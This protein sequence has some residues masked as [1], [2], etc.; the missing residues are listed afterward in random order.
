MIRRKVG[1]FSRLKLSK[2]KT[3]ALLILL[4]AAILEVYIHTSRYRI[5]VPER[6]LDE[7]FYTSC[8]EPPDPKDKSRPRANAALVMLVRN[9]E[10]DGAL[11]TVASVER[12][13][14]RWF[15]YP[16]VFLNDEPWTE[17]FKTAMRA[18]ISGEVRFEAIPTREWTFP[19]WMDT[20]AARASIKSQGQWM[21]KFAGL[22]TYHH[23]CR[24]YSGKFYNL[25]ALRQYKWYWRIEPGVEFYCDITYDPFLEMEKNG[26]VYGHTIAVPEG[27]RTCPS[28]FRRMSDWKEAHHIRDTE[29]WKTMVSPSW[30]PWPLRGLLAWL[31]WHRDR[32]G[33]AWSLCH[34][35]SNFEIASLDFFRSKAYQEL[36]EYLDSTGGFYYERVSL[37]PWHTDGLGKQ[38]NGTLDGS[39]ETRQCIPWPWGCCWMQTRSIILRTLGIGMIIGTSVRQMLREG[40]SSSPRFST[41]PLTRSGTMVLGAAASAMAVRRGTG[42]VTVWL[43]SRRRR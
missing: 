7:P 13:F 19:A 33:D 1:R 20:E 29:L 34:Y 37:E 5:R 2:T 28:L 11:Q 24:F 15:R 36:F 4:L 21:I 39:G 30:A 23:M 3:I 12:K 40:S 26:K 22:E 10:L 27:P 16:I 14:N 31:S 42:R 35:W 38:A 32:N 43:S 6:D 8:Q 9:K 41:A 17:E 18:A 25:E